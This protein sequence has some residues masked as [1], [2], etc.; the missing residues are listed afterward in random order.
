MQIYI[1][2]IRKLSHRLS[3][4]PRL[5]DLGFETGFLDSRASPLT[6]PFTASKN[7]AE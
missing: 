2:Q 4:F 7:Y 5:V 3:N 6:T 1:L